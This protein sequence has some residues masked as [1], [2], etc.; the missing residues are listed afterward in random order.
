MDRKY[1]PDWAKYFQ[2][3]I[4]ELK[5]I[6]TIELSDYINEGQPFLGA[7]LGN[8]E[9]FLSIA[10]KFLEK[11]VMELVI[12]GPKVYLKGFEPPIEETK[13]ESDEKN[14]Q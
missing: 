2:E 13:K 8:C 4:E 9:K 10:E 12:R 1:R 3:I 7:N 6:D 14:G 11:N 5:V